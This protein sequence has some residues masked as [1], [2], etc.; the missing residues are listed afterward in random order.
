M[1][2]PRATLGNCVMGNLLPP[3]G[4]TFPGWFY[5]LMIIS[6]LTQALENPFTPMP[7]GTPWGAKWEYGWFKTSLIAPPEA[8]GQRLVFTASPADQDP[9]PANAWSG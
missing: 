2:A 6:L 5:N 4:G 9:Y 3:I 8:A 1:A 7:P